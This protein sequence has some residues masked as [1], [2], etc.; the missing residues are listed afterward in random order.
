MKTPCNVNDFPGFKNQGMRRGHRRRRLC[1]RRAPWLW[2]PG[3]FEIPKL[4][5]MLLFFSKLNGGI[6]LGAKIGFCDIVPLV[7]AGLGLPNF[8]GRGIE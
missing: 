1:A 2:N 3:N 6:I 5:R 7:A 4:V 8:P